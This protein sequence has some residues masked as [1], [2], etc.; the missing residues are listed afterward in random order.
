MEICPRVSERE[1]TQEELFSA[2]LLCYQYNNKMLQL[3]EQ[4][5]GFHG[6]NIGAGD[7]S[8]NTY[9]SSFSHFQLIELPIKIIYF[10]LLIMFQYFMILVWPWI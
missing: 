9:I 6:I 2:F 8:Q 4:Q 1:K 10:P 7:D 5:L 3:H